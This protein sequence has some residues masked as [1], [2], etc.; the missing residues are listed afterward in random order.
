MR[1]NLI[2]GLD[3]GSTKTCVVIGEFV[4]EFKRPELKILGVGQAPTAGIR[5][6]AVTNLEEATGGIR[7]AIEEAELM[8][9]ARI[10]RAY[11]GIS[12]EHVQAQRSVG[13]V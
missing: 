8:S 9:G 13:V 7:R 2:A 3:I 10:D 11:V 4:D 5:K 12:G 1:S 6:D